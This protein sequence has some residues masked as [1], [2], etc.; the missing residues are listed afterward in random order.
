MPRWT[1]Y[2]KSGLLFLLDQWFLVTLGVLIGLAYAF[3]D[4][5][6]TGGSVR[7]EYTIEYGAVAMIFLLSGRALG[8]KY[9][10]EQALLDAQLFIFL[11]YS[12]IYW[13]SWLTPPGAS[14]S[15]QALLQNALNYK[16][17]L[18]TQ[19]TSFVLFSVVNLSIAYLVLYTSKIDF[20]ILTGFIILGCTATAIASNVIMTKK[21][22]GDDAAALIEA[23]L[24]N[25]LGTFITPALLQLYLRESTG[26]E[27]GKPKGSIGKIYAR[28]LQQLGTCVIG[29]LIV[30]QFLRTINPKKVDTVFQK[31]YLNKVGSFML[32]LLIWATFSNAFSS[33]AFQSLSSNSILFMLLTNIALYLVFTILCVYLALAA[34]FSKKQAIAIAYCGAGKTPAVGIPLIHSQYQGFSQIIR[35]KLTIPLVLYQGEQLV[36]GQIL[37][38]LGRWWVAREAKGQERKSNKSIHPNDQ[39]D[40]ESRSSRIQD[41]ISVHST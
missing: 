34:G 28:V 32:L 38:G 39:S 5:G 8:I 7:S 17:H 27:A 25:V 1:D 40:V 30:G 29:A 24:G 3:P 12:T 16:L 23:C 26:F 14:S 15:S 11:F 20:Y 41:T 22:G 6:K 31:L 21:A 37:T 33:G 2:A 13:E 10:T 35:G 4:V 19:L 18:V 36:I 9:Q